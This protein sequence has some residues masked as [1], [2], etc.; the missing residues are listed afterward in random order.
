[1]IREGNEVRFSHYE[2]Q[3]GGN[4]VAVLVPVWPSNRNTKYRYDKNSLAL[5]IKALQECGNYAEV[6]TL[7]MQNWPT[8]P[9]QVK[10]G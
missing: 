2:W 4:C 8:K 7:A 1:M 6:S 5:R 3:T 9:P 10:F